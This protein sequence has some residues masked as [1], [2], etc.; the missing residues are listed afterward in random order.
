MSKTQALWLKPG[1]Y[2]MRE[3][4]M[5]RDLFV[6]I[7][8]E[9]IVEIEGRR[10]GTITTQGDVIG[11]LG[12][13]SKKP[14]TASVFARV[15]S[16]VLVIKEATA[17]SLTRIPSVLEKID[18]AITRRFHVARNKTRMYTSLISTIKRSILQETMRT[19]AASMKASASPWED[20]GP[21]IKRH[22]IRRRIDEA[23]ERFGNADDHKAFDRIAT[24]WGVL[25]IF[26]DQLAMRPWL[27]DSLP[28]R[29]ERIENEWNLIGDQHSADS[30][31][32]KANL[33]VSMSMLLTQ[34]DQ[35]PGI[36]REMDL[37]RMEG[38]VPAVAKID[39]LKVAFFSRFANGLD[40]RER[41]FSERKIKLAIEGVKADAGDDVTL[42]LN[43]AKELGIESEYEAQL[44][45]I[46][47][48]TEADTVFNDI[49]SGDPVPRP[50]VATKP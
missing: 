21:D 5:S 9:L 26:R 14:R 10:I 19:H 44:R 39:A 49:S 34:F 1:D 36:K 17:L 18:A 20:V 16:E 12:A 27:D 31:V 50:L 6:F 42:V 48:L 37:L 11:E 24:E 8:G 43:A 4:E 23:T 15:P 3:K 41:T 22:Q 35:M 32:R 46:V 33:A 28:D 2:I 7:S 25:N 47:G 30:V 45:N 38:I 40:D 29:L 13:L